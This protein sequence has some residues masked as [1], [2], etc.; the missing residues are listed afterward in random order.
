MRKPLIALSLAISTGVGAIPVADAMAATA[1]PAHLEQGSQPPRSVS[2]TTSS[3]TYSNASVT[4]STHGTNAVSGAAIVATAM[5]YRGFPYTATGNSP[6]T[7]FS[8]IGFVSFV[9]RSNGIQLPGDL[10][11]ALAY[12]P[13][14]PFSDLQPGDILY[15]QNTVWNGISHAAIYI[16]GGRFIHAEWYNRGVVISSFNN[17]PVDGNYWIGKYLGANRPYQ[18]PAAGSVVTPTSTSVVTGAQQTPATTVAQPVQIQSGP[19]ALVSVSSLNVRTSPSL[20][21]GVQQVVYQG[22]SMTVLGKRN[23]WY[24][25]QLS[26]GTV[27]WVVA[28]G[29]GKGSAPKA[30]SSPTQVPA[31]ASP[32]TTIGNPVSP[33]HLQSP[34]RRRAVAS[35]T[36]TGLR[37]RSEPSTTG[38]IVTTAP[39]GQRLVI[40][41]RANGWMKVRLPDGTVGW[42]TSSYTSA[43]HAG[44]SRSK[45]QQ[46]STSASAKPGVGVTVQVA[47]NL[48]SGPSLTSSVQTVLSPGSTYHILGRSNGWIH[49]RMADGTVG[50]INAGAATGSSNSAGTGRSKAARYGVST[51]GGSVITTVVRV[52]VAPSF[53]GTVV[54]TAA[55]GT[56]V[57]VLYRSG[58]WVLVQ[59]P[60][61][62]TGY[63]P[64]AYVR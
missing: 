59:L 12:A 13:Q 50:W 15:F 42:V 31:T 10:A 49:V 55:G 19:S 27:G 24:K 58:A 4:A 9:Y 22:T 21:A 30:P 39:Q 41:Q 62:T 7:G 52:R 17:D 56:R 40:L 61:G 28:Q 14:V 5:K 57:Q 34:T 45:A 54:T 38:T 3:P 16:G 35:V 25:V 2:G 44:T 23:G 20:N 26:D 29:I 6:S 63:V 51:R 11:G 48:R 32:A 60:N 46:V 43:S 37:V 18:G 33:T 1:T 53:R 8:C 36:V 64:G 47:L